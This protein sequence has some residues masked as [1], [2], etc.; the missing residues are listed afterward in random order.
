MNRFTTVKWTAAQPP[1]GV[2]PPVSGI[3]GLL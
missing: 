1:A 3:V 2:G